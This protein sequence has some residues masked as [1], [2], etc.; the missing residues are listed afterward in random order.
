MFSNIGKFSM[1]CLGM[2][3][4]KNVQKG[5]E[6]RDSP[7]ICKGVRETGNLKDWQI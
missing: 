4:H 3:M 6:L 7:K 1:S 2:A 5:I